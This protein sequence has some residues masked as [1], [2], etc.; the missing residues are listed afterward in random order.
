MDSLE[1]QLKSLAMHRGA[2]LV[3]VTSRGMLADGPPSA[4]PRYLLPTANAVI[5]FARALDGDAV[6]N[7]IAKRSWR[8]HCENRKA[9]VRGLYEI[10]DALADR[11][12]AEGYEAV[13]VDINNNYRP[14][15]AAADVTE[16]TEFHPEFAH[17][18]AALGAGIGRLGW[19]GNLLTRE[20]GAL[21]ELGGDE[22]GLLL[23]E[24]GVVGPR[25]EEAPG[26]AGCQVEL[27][28]Q[29]HWAVV[30]V[31]L[32][33]VADLVVHLTECHCCP[34]PGRVVCCVPAGRRGHAAR[35]RPPPGQ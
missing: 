20:Y 11:L 32:L 34:L 4:D 15:E 28:D 16:M 13:N 35:G 21:V 25:L 6:E 18:Y 24:R 14:E 3:G 8:P 30:V 23:H 26:V 33:G 10:G 31:E 29:D 17:R 9:T 12:R 27:V 22:A 5:S 19:S 7:F 2:D 1:E